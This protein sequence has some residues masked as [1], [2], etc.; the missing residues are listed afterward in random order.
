[1]SRVMKAIA[2]FLV[3]V[4]I[5]LGAVGEPRN[6]ERIVQDLVYRGV[7]GVALALD[8]YY[9]QTGSSSERRGQVFIFGVF[10]T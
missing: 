2:A 3:V 4:L 8:L 1:M 6:A 5:G 10:G 7:D 9:P